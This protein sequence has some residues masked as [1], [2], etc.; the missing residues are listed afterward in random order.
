V[1]LGRNR[2]PEKVLRLR[3]HQAALWT[4]PGCRQVLAV[5]FAR[6][7]STLRPSWEG[8]A[9][10][11]GGPGEPVYTRLARLRRQ[12][13]CG[14]VSGAAFLRLADDLL[15]PLSEDASKAFIADPEQR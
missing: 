2:K 6:G 7:A 8:K 13:R 9:E 5:A 12:H 3:H 11:A 4:C 1:T 15:V 10:E 14:P